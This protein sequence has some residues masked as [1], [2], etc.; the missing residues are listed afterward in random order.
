MVSSS[1]KIALLGMAFIA[2]VSSAQAAVFN[3]GEP[4]IQNGMKIQ[5]LYIQSVKVESAPSMMMDHSQHGMPNSGATSNEMSGMDHGDHS[6][7]QDTGD[8][9]LE[10]DIKASGDN[11]WGFPEGAWIP[12]LRI[13][14]T[15]KQLS[16]KYMTS[17]TLY[18][19]AAND[20]PHYGNNVTLNGAGKYKLQLRVS[21]PDNAVFMRHFDRETGVA[22][23]WKGFI[24]SSEFV[25]IGVGK[26]GG[27]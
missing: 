14:Y 12:Y 9:H 1:L 6:G 7:H 4:R 2:S 8:I 3:I 19:M 15:I 11:D 27:Y 18:P 23:W 26:K 13:E 20:G 21:P 22:G 24:F 17:G 16:G 10:V 25:Y 5:P